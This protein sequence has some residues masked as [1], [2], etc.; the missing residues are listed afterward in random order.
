MGRRLDWLPLR[1][2]D[3]NTGL[4]VPFVQET[5]DVVRI[6][7]LQLARGAWNTLARLLQLACLSLDYKPLL[8]H[9]M[10]H[11]GATGVVLDILCQAPRYHPAWK[12]LS[13]AGAGLLGALVRCEDDG[14]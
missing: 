7:I 8:A 14:T 11:A 4:D 9:E 3:D 6:L 13:T 12:A 5:P 2:S 10:A 1:P